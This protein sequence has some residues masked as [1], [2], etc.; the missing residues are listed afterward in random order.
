VAK[1]KITKRAVDALRAGETLFDSEVRGF[2]VRARAEAKV[3]GLKYVVS[4][5]QRIL[6]L[7]EHGPLTAEEAR[8]S[9]EEA[10]AAVS[11]GSDPQAARDAAKARS[12]AASFAQ[13][14]E[15]YDRR[16]L[17][18]NKP[19]SVAEERRRLRLHLLP[20][21]GT[22]PLASITKADVLRLKDRLA[23]RPVAF[24]RCRAL[25]HSMFER[26]RQWDLHTGP[27]PASQVAKHKE[28]RRERFLSAAEYHRLFSA[29][30]RA[31]GREHPSVLVCVRLLALT[32][33]RLSEILTLQ[34]AQVDFDNAAL[35]LPDSKSGAKIIPL[36]APALMLLDSL[37]RVS[38]YVCPGASLDAPLAPPQRQWR[39]IRAAAKLDDL[40]LHDLR[41]G[42]ASVNRPG[43]PGGSRLRES[44]AHGTETTPTEIFAGAA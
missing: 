2:M 39:R 19:R 22:R 25:L 16:H 21:F 32:G 42:F 44:G 3:Y 24:N 23:D 6:T 35:R 4:G 31:A 38:T 8:R 18:G 26:A 14:S 41:H 12:E 13:F 29:L 1:G 33:A 7:G 34:W 15:L 43:F 17:V 20:L 40:R 30:D 36:G 27:N 37:P 5:R 10:R 11:R 28:T 9:A